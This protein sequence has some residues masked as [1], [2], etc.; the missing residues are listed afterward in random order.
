MNKQ[1]D[2]CPSC[3]GFGE[4]FAPFEQKSYPCFT[5]NETGYIERE[6][7]WIEQGKELKRY[8]LEELG[9]GLREACRKYK[10][11]AS[12]L[13][14]MERGIIKPQSPKEIYG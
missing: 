5:C 1:T 13:S 6:K 11:D 12:N 10:Y 3:D 2:K 14:R 8:R 9:L 4:I 7:V